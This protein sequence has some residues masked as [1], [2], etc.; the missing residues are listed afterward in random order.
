MSLAERIMKNTQQ[1]PMNQSKIDQK[2]EHNKNIHINI[3][4]D[5][6]TESKST[7][8]V[9][10]KQRTAKMTTRKTYFPS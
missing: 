10:P 2:Q 7:H 5:R 3:K 9:E 4:K 6:N 1:V 8:G